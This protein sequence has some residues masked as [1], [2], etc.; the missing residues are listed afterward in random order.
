MLPEVRHL[1]WTLVWVE[2]S[3]AD[4][5][6]AWSR[7]RRQHQALM[8]TVTINAVLPTINWNSCCS[9]QLSSLPALSRRSSALKGRGIFK[10]KRGLR[11]SYSPSIPSNALLVRNRWNY[12]GW[13]PPPLM[14]REMPR[15]NGLL[16]ANWTE[17]EAGRLSIHMRQYRNRVL[18]A[19]SFHRSLR[20]LH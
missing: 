18:E 9:I 3:S 15:V 1:L 8:N 20:L 4:H 14:E 13:I 11:I 2:P 12:M 19:S 16:Y 5:V 6:H 7:R 17:E 10:G